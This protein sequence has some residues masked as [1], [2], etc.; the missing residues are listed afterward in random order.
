MTKKVI[1]ISSI[2]SNRSIG[3]N[4]NLIFSISS[5]MKHFSK[6]TTITQDPTK[7]NAVIMGKNTFMSMSLSPLPKR[8]NYVISNTLNKENFQNYSNLYIYK[9]IENCF[10]DLQKNEEIENIYIIGGEGIYKYFLDNNY[11]DELILTFVKE[12]IISYGDSFFPT[13][14][15]SKYQITSLSKLTSDGTEV[16]S[17]KKIKIDYEI[18]YIKKNNNVNL[19]STCLGN[20]KNN[21]LNSNNHQEYQYLNIIKDTLY[22]G[23]LKDSRNSKVL[24]SKFK[25]MDFDISKDFPLLTTKKVYFNGVIKE[26]IWFLGGNTDANILANQG[27]SIWNGNS[28]R[29]YLDNIGLTHYKEGECGPI[30]GYQWRHFNHKYEGCDKN[31]DNKGIDQL[32]NVISLIKHNPYSRRILMTAWNPCQLQEMVLPPCHVS[33]QFIVENCQE[34]GDKKLSCIMYQRS[35]DLFLGIP[36][37]IASTALLTY[38]IADITNTIPD[39]I[40]IVIADAHIYID[41]IEQ[42]KIQ[43]KRIPYQFP[44]LK[45]KNKITNIDKITFDDVIL[46]NYEY[47]PTIK[48]KMIA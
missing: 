12:P 1:C 46:E 19:Y 2:A 20:F 30:Y 23:T 26:L 17:N 32:L 40:S 38:I 8:K 22:H 42:I 7:I 13:F 44:K 6:T 29:S 15:T 45:F 25:K 37:N 39:K 14:D 24:S 11:V 18:A 36:F 21:Y 9:N 3:F 43:L 28:S 48:A 34:T 41:H 16:V 35:G 31:Y 27:V 5:E 10:N 4:H 47:H 33:Y